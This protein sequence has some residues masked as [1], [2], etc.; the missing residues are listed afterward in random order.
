MII[1]WLNLYI[2]H[3]FHIESKSGYWT[4][5]N[6]LKKIKMDKR[7]EDCHIAKIKNYIK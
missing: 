1:K 2:T 5:N 4:M 3:A 6:N 7:K